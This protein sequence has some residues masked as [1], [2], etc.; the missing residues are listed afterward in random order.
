M[1]TKEKRYMKNS[2]FRIFFVMLIFV[3]IPFSAY[4]QDKQG[5]RL[6]IEE[7]EFDFGQ[8]K[9]GSRITHNFTILNRGDEILEIKKVSPG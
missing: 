7:R 8:V 2:V 5:P 3:I 9:Q 1:D 6:V 4:S